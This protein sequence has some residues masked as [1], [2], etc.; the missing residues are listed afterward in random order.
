MNY[1]IVAQLTFFHMNVRTSESYSHKLG[2]TETQM[3]YKIQ[4]EET[5][6][7]T[8]IYAEITHFLVLSTMLGMQKI[9][10]HPK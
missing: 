10:K 5:K 4:Q 6:V 2:E 3:Q 7:K 8:Y 1:S 9:G